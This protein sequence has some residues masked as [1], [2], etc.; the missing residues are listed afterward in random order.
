MT[1]RASGIV[2]A[3]PEELLAG[4]DDDQRSVAE[5][6]RGPVCVLAGAGTGKTRAI[7]H[8]IAYGVATGTY[9]PDRVLALTFTNRAAG[10]MRTRLRQLGAGPVQA[11]TFHAAA[12]R[13][14]GHFWPLFVGGDAPKVFDSKSRPLAEV[15]TKLGLK[16]DTA[17]LR[18]LASEVEWRK[19]SNL[20]LGSYEKR[21]YARPMPGNLAVSDVL[22]VMS[23]Y[24]DLKDDRGQI[25]MEDVLL[26]TA[27]LLESEAAAAMEVRER[28]RFF[29]V[30]EYQDVSPLQH[31]L[32]SLWLGDHRDLCVVGDASQTIYSFTG[33]TSDYLLDFGQAY[34]DAHIVKLETNY[35]ST[36][37][38]VATANALMRD[39]PGALTL[40][41][42]T[43]DGPAPQWS[44]YPHD[45]AEA[46]G[47]ATKIAAE[48]AAGTQPENI[49]VLYRINVQGVALE[50]A[51]SDL[52]I[53]STIH[54]AQRF[55]DLP[56]VKQAIM[57][58]R[59]AS[60]SVAG[61]PLF[62]SVSDV[63]RS[64][65][66]SQEA[67]HTTGAARAKWEALNALMVMADE[68]PEGTSFRAF[69]DELLARQAARHE[70][71]LHA[72][73]LASVHSAKGLEWDS[74][75]VIGL[76][77][78]LFPIS[79]AQDLE[80]I[81]EERRLLYVAITRAR[82]QLSL[83]WA[84]QGTGRAT[85]RERSRFVAELGMHNPGAGRK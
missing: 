24:E 4:L 57:A 22:S 27:G 76:S 6:L 1:S 72:V 67:P 12:L 28:Y 80:A 75:H 77:E 85:N 47:V 19:T 56:E 78:G 83:S 2:A 14:L 55:Y 66:W 73:T 69:T 49:A 65:G 37:P 52:G 41:A 8:R 18:D 51:L 13:Q 32:L 3:T 5:E 48:I 38:I 29:V 35:R 25:D 74:V 15:A 71:T 11:Q 79:Y 63:L 84:Q 26:L 42:A 23:G 36:A 7:T 54:G 70:P 58:L 21:A 20:N 39:R 53:S 60:V 33:A 31:H 50:Q 61:E 82:Q 81:A 45:A 44:E 43:P 68:A 17:T 64:V 30:D 9:A 59:G 16:L 40:T 10:E 46:R 62:K 34:P